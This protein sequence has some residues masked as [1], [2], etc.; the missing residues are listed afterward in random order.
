MPSV[1]NEAYSLSETL[2]YNET[3]SFATT[4]PR[5]TWSTHSMVIFHPPWPHGHDFVLAQCWLQTRHDAPEPIEV[6]NPPEYEY[7]LAEFMSRPRAIQDKVATN[8]GMRL[9]E[10][11]GGASE[12]RRRKQTGAESQGDV[13]GRSKRR[14]DGYTSRIPARSPPSR[15]RGA[16]DK[17][18]QSYS[19]STCRRRDTTRD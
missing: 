15:V 19:Q 2:F 3:V 16:R 5:F 4:V 7:P 18:G 12:G 6:K 14:R 11:K 10:G 8:W 17:A 9:G 1:R 13:A